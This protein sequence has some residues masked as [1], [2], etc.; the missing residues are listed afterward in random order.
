MNYS[1]FTLWFTGFSGA[2]KTT[3][4]KGVALELK[5]RGCRVE[6]LDGDTV[7][8][9]LSSEL[10]FS[11]KD[12][13]TNVRRIGFVSSLLSR[14]QVIA[15]VAAISP[16]RDV[17]NE[18]RHMNQTFVEVYVKASLEACEQRDVKGLYALARAGKVKEFTGI[19]SPYE[20]PLNPEIT[21]NTQYETINESIAKVIKALEEY[22]Y[23]PI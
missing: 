3:I 15:I 4:S 14:N 22:G 8:T 11:K 21:C 18:V 7:R 12:R 1:G 10:G 20:E 6:V 23:I 16:Y 17:R 9:Y 2:G 13:D 5:A 19:D